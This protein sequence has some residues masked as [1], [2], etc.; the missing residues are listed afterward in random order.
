[1]TNMGRGVTKEEANV[2]YPYSYISFMWSSLRL[3]PIIAQSL[4][5][6][7]HL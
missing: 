4:S 3:T 1:M 2:P 5:T 6:S 7:S